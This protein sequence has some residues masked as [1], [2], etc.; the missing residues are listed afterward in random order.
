MEFWARL[1][2]L[3]LCLFKSFSFCNFAIEKRL[4][5]MNENV[6][7]FLDSYIL[8][9]DPQYAVMLTGRWGCGKTYF[10]RKWL[11]GKEETKNEREEVLYLNPIYVSLFGMSSIGDVKKE[12]DRKLNPFFYS[13][14]GKFI[15]GVAKLASKVVFKTDLTNDGAPVSATCSLDFM[16]LFEDGPDNVEGTR[17]IVFDDLERTD[18]PLKT[19]LGFVDF[20]VDRCKFHVVLIGDD[21]KMK[22]DD[23]E[24][25]NEF[26]EKVIGRQFELAPDVEAALDCFVEDQQLCDFIRRERGYILKCFNATKYGNLRLLR[27]CLYDYNIVVGKFKKKDVERNE[28]LFRSVLASFIAVYAEYNNSEYHDTIATWEGPFLDYNAIHRDEPENK[29]RKLIIKYSGIS[30]DNMYDVLSYGHVKNIVA[31]LSIGM[32]LCPYLSSLFIVDNV[33]KTIEQKFHNYWWMST[34]EFKGVYESVEEE[35]LQGKLNI[36]ELGRAIGFF[37]VFDSEQLQMLKDETLE[38]LKALLLRHISEADDVAALVKL[39]NT[40]LGG[41]RYVVMTRNEALRTD[42]LIQEFNEGIDKRQKEIPDDMQKILRSLTD[43]N[44]AELVG[45][46][47][48][49][50]PDHS[51]AY[52]LM[53]VLVNEDADDLFKRLCRMTNKGRWTF[54]DFLVGHYN[55]DH[56]SSFSEAY[57]EDYNVL[58]ELCEKVQGMSDNDNTEGT[59]RMSYAELAK[60]LSQCLD[61]AKRHS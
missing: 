39:K 26:K 36:N 47:N 60:R 7:N 3:I 29:C 45:C 34:D 48:K 19:L 28:A 52:N 46:D 1:K 6:S 12:I 17:F 32:D 38:K 53:P 8:N 49:S 33:N 30:E 61:K 23:K 14:T 24:V 16:S 41:Y 27:Q 2:K 44:V 43:E 13:K 18:I 40:F 55:L 50:Y 57:A 31:Y 20:F 22:K 54:V 59:E 56:A 58:N 42:L 11:G 9:P 37:A 25:Y 21:T 4:S 10:I 5:A 15:K 35:M 51:R